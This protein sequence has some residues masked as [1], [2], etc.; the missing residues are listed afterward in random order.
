M[1]VTMNRPK[2]FLSLE[3]NILLKYI[4]IKCSKTPLNNDFFCIFMDSICSY[5]NVD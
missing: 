5:T 2:C 3:K 4:S 1:G